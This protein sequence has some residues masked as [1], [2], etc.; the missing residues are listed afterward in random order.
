MCI[1]MN[2]DVQKWSTFNLGAM[3][4]VN[5]CSKLAVNSLLCL[6]TKLGDQSPNDDEEQD[7]ADQGWWQLWCQRSDK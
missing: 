1:V 4:F 6:K 5:N 3:G 2:R 7:R